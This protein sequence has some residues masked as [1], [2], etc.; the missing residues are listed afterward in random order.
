MNDLINRHDIGVTAKIE[1]H[2]AAALQLNSV[3]LLLIKITDIGD[4]VCE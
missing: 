1:T 3:E 2:F 4:I